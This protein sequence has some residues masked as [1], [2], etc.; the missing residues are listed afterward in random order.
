MEIMSQGAEELNRALHRLNLET[1]IW[2]LERER[3][4][5]GEDWFTPGNIDKDKE[6]RD[7]YTELVKDYPAD[8]TTEARANLAKLDSDC[9]HRRI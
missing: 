1:Q 7:A 6:L 3:V 9:G 4:R 2:A 8:T 5:V